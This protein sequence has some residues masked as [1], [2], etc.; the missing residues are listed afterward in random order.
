MGLSE[1]VEDAESSPAAGEDRSFL[2][3]GSWLYGPQKCGSCTLLYF[4]FSLEPSIKPNSLKT[5]CPVECLDLLA[6]GGLNLLK[7]SF[8]GAKAV[9]SLCSQA[10]RR[11]PRLLVLPHLSPATRLSCLCSI[12]SQA[13]SFPGS[14]RTAALLSRNRLSQQGRQAFETYQRARGGTKRDFPA[15]GIKRVCLGLY[16]KFPSHTE[17]A[18]H[19]EKAG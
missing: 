6:Q 5:L 10:S 13:V 14:C 15:G 3:L 17:A 12:D 19:T 4:D 18:A 2:G 9:G 7:L 11:V 16:A 8:I 1:E